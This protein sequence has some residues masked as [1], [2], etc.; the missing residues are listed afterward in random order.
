MISNGHLFASLFENMINGC[1]HCQAIYDSDGQLIDWVT[2][3]INDAFEKKTGLTKEVIGKR[4]SV[5]YPEMYET[6]RIM[7]KAFERV[8]KGGPPE[9]METYVVPLQRWHLQ[10]VYSVDPGTFTVIFSDITEH[11]NIVA[12]LEQS[13]KQIELAYDETML[14]LLRA[15]RFRDLESEKHSFRV[16]NLT[17]RLAKALSITDEQELTYYRRGALLHDIGKLFIPDS[18]LLKPGKHDPEERDL[19]KQ[20]TTFAFEFLKPLTFIS[21][22]IIDIPH[23]HHERWDGS[24]YPRGLKAMGIPY[25]A[26]VFALADVYDAM[27]SDRPYRKALSHEF[28]WKYI[29]SQSGIQFNP[30]ITKVFTEMFAENQEG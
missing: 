21:E 1:A 12:T 20:H 16:V 19:M 28:V 14:G 29:Y 18:I 6:N 10:S 4:M 30:K 13:H 3:L 11:K 25:A 7:I 5:V 17:L 8:S 24:G 15:L 2:L 26:Q 9:T 22:T 27:T 23:Y